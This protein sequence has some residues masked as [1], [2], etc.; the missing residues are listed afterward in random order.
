MENISLRVI[1]IY[2]LAKPIRGQF[3]KILFGSERTCRF[4][5]TCSDYAAQAIKKHGIYGFGLAAWR[6]LRCNPFGGK[7]FDPVK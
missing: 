4:Y 3:T 7:G 5:P 6:I 1:K 2:Q